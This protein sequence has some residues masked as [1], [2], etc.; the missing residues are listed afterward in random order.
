MTR[1]YFWS[2]FRS[3]LPFLLV[4]CPYAL[5]FGVIATEA[6]LDLLK[7]MSMSVLIIAG[8]A[9]FVSVQMMIDD[10]PVAVVLLTA[11]AVNMRMAMYS[12]SMAP[13]MGAAPLWQRALAAYFLVD[14]SYGV[15]IQ[16]FEEA[17]QMN[18]S[19]KMAFFFGAVAPVCPLWYLFTWIGAVAGTR[20]P[21]DYALDFAMPITFIA[22]FAPMLKSLAHVSAATVSVL[23]A[24]ALVWVPYNLGLI[25]TGLAA[26]LT[27]A[28]VET[29]K[30]SRA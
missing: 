23:G 25:V 14:Q 10:A 8:A 22:L 15:S 30:E 24:L 19:E 13:H 26:M 20:I 3:G 16:Q 7:V 29:W 27:G 18:V 1:S 17:R 11:L 6:G 2:G 28:L 5:L 4:I 21:P 12:A 9:Q